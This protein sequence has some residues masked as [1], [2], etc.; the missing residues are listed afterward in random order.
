MSFCS[1]L[2]LK[3]LI[4]PL[5]SGPSG[6]GKTTLLDILT[7]R[8]SVGRVEGSVTYN[9]AAV[10]QAH[11]MRLH[12]AYVMQEESFHATSTVMEAM[13][14]QAHMR[15]PRSVATAVKRERARRLLETA[16]LQ[17]K[18]DVRIGGELPGG[19]PVRGLSGGEKRR[20]SLCCGVVGDPKVLFCD[21]VTSGTYVGG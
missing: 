4:D 18:E 3:P 19:F 13:L 9:G 6:A 21:E 1:P 12:S 11:D 16:G 10:V 17:E 15:M 14:F 20:L 5:L 8:K 2:K 7:R